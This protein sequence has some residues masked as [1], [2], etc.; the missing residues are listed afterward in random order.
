MQPRFD[1]EIDLNGNDCSVYIKNLNFE[2]RDPQVKAWTEDTLRKILEVVKSVRKV[3]AALK[4]GALWD[5]YRS[6]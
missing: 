3:K 6:M 1:D 4:R 2:I 5:P